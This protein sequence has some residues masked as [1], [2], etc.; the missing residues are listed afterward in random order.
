MTDERAAE[1]IEFAVDQSKKF[2]GIDQE[3]RIAIF[4]RTVDLLSRSDGEIEMFERSSREMGERIMSLTKERD[5]LLKK[6]GV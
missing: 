4:D 1:I 3:F 2:C 6:A 5:E